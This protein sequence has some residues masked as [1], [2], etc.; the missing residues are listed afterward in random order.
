MYGEIFSVLALPCNAMREVR[1]SIFYVCKD[2]ER[3]QLESEAVS[4]ETITATG[5]P[6]ALTE[7]YPRMVAV[8]F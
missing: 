4:T 1:D 6:G 5:N 2:N 8:L 3:L 7:L